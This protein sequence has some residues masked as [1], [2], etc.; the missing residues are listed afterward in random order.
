MNIVFDIARVT[1]SLGFN[2]HMKY[3]KGTEA[4][5]I[6]IINTCNVD[7]A[8]HM[9]QKNKS[10]LYSIYQAA[11]GTMTDPQMDKLF[12]VFYNGMETVIETP[13]DIEKNWCLGKDWYVNADR[14]GDRLTG[15]RQTERWTNHGES[16]DKNYSKGIK[17]L[18]EER[19]LA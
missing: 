17:A 9:M 8:K 18:E 14:I 3:W 19:K 13:N 4:E 15:G 7:K 10:I 5:I 12:S 1:L 16:K 2:G 11:Y 6:E